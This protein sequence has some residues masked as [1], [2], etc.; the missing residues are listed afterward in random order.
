MLNEPGAA[1][2]LLEEV[3]ES[4]QTQRRSD[5]SYWS[6]YA[7]VLARN[8]EFDRALDIADRILDVDPSHEDMRQLKASILNRRGEHERVPSLVDDPTVKAVLEAK[9]LA[10]EGDLDGALTILTQAVAGDPTN[11]QL[12]S[13][14]VGE[15][16]NRDRTADAQAVV[17]RALQAMPDSPDFQALK[18]WA[19]PGLSAEQRDEAFLEIIE[20]E[21]DAYRRSL[22]LI[23]YHLRR[24]D[25]A[26]ALESIDEAER[27]F[28]ERSTPFA[29]NA[30]MAHY[31]ALLKEKLR[32][33]MALGREDAM[34]EARDSAVAHDVDGVRGM[35]I[36]G[37]YHMY[38]NE[39]EAALSAFRNATTLQPTDVAS[40]VQL[41]ACYQRLSQL[42]EAEV[43]YQRALRINPSEPLAHMGL[44]QLAEVR[45]DTAVYERELTFCA[46][47]LPEH[48]W[49]KAGL[50]AKSEE[51]T[52]LA[53][54]ERR[55]HLLADQP[56]DVRNLRRLAELC[57]NVGELDKADTFQ[58]RLLTLLPDD[59]TVH[60]EVS[61]YYR[62]TGRPERSLELVTRFADSRATKEERANAAILVASHYLNLG[63]LDLVETTLLGA[64]D[65]AET[66]EVA[67]SLG[68]FY[69]HLSDRGSDALRWY[70]RAVELA[71]EA[72]SPDLPRILAARIT[73]TLSRQV[74]DLK[75]ARRYVDELLGQYP[76]DPKG[77][78]L[79]SEVYARTGDIERAIAALNRYL[80]AHPKDAAVMF[81]R[82]RH[83]VAQGQ[84]GAAIAD[85]EAL[86]RADPLALD[87]QPRF[88]LAK[89]HRQ[90]GMMQDWVR[91][92]ESLVAA[93]PESREALEALVSAYIQQ[94]RVVEADR[95]VTTQINQAEDPD[96][97]WYELRGR[98]SRELGDRDK[99]LR[100]F[101]RSA[102]LAGFDLRSLA[103]LLD[104][105][106]EA[107]RAQEA[108]AYF[109]PHLERLKEE[110]ELMARFAVALAKA[111]QEGRA[112]ETFRRAMAL[113]EAN[114]S[115]T[116]GLVAR[117]ILRAVSADRAVAL[118]EQP[119]SDPAH[120]RNNDRILVRLYL[121]QG[122]YDDALGLVDQLLVGSSTDAERAQLLREKGDVL[123]LSDRQEDARQAY[124]EALRWDSENWMVL[125]NLAYVL[126]DGLGECELARPYAER[127]V[128]ISESTHTLDTLGWILVCLGD[129][130]QAIAELNP[131]DSTR[132][133]LAR[134][135]PPP[136][137]G[138]SP[139]R[140]VCQ[141]G[142]HPAQRQG[143]CRN[144]WRR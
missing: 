55:E 32:T 91:E 14:L 77:L 139:K 126:S 26:S 20:N 6:L 58:H 132:F 7:Q 89:L 25:H 48:P 75:R 47:V 17:E 24:Q 107:D 10:L 44:G 112:V 13:T 141:C 4:A 9:Q 142:D 49:V 128:V 51:A 72:E 114:A 35:S 135:L 57:E 50:L 39:W 118:F 98:I 31:R 70:D 122:R 63:E 104:E 59:R 115:Q 79:D 88:L 67:R 81:Q 99:A 65:L 94:R 125:N 21:P 117:Q 1:K 38:R 71:R 83:Y 68:E 129:F 97:R 15:L 92:L 37:L 66:L 12:V 42:D 86:K 136:R 137:G 23:R 96:P 64:V 82:A 2:T 119:G 140:S 34:I 36:V 8:Q 80:T 76:D 116:S 11:V 84:I 33:A 46:K 134:L 103:M 53:A 100:D 69:L 138:V 133:K 18:V 40:L 101:K 130:P 90:N 111:G 16:V 110:P 60:V 113:G 102:E 131:R 87:L 52:P 22:D 45:G 5:V 27:L 123:N 3:A 78:L 127:A 61:R 28:I 41:G 124:Q 93:A 120:A 62:R 73:C 121:T 106:I 105:F 143:T 108:V 74:N 30:T 95:I 19:D 144:G 85:L 56:D 29:R 43:A 54:I 109:G